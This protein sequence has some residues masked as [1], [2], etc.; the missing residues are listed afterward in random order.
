MLKIR[1]APGPTCHWIGPK[2]YDLLSIKKRINTGDP[3]FVTARSSL[4]QERSM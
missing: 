3:K 4:P 1:F 2:D